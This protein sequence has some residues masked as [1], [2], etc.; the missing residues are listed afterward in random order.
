MWSP[1]A[2]P[3][4]VPA[5][6]HSWRLLENGWPQRRL[7]H[8]L[9]DGLP[10]ISLSLQAPGDQVWEKGTFPIHANAYSSWFQLGSPEV[11]GIAKFQGGGSQ[12]QSRNYSYGSESASSGCSACGDEWADGGRYASVG[13][14]EDWMRIGNP[15]SLWTQRKTRSAVFIHSA[16]VYWIPYCVWASGQRSDV[17]RTRG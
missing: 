6:W 10:V 14:S 13:H 5:P 8:T 9:P 3:Q 1:R 4:P 11:E 17:Q 16:T 12:F 7:Q 15:E 2:T